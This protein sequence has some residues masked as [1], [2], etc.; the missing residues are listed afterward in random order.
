MGG[1]ICCRDW[2]NNVGDDNLYL[3]GGPAYFCPWCGKKKNE[4]DMLTQKE[5]NALELLLNRLGFKI[6]WG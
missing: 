6:R 2:H 3:Y 5:W 1:K 4:P